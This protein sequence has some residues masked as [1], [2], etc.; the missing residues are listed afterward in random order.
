RLDTDDPDVGQQRLEDDGDAGDEAT[1]ADRHQDD[2]QLG[3]F[4]HQFERQ[5]A[6]AG[7]DVRVVERVDRGQATL[8]P[9]RLVRGEQVA[10]GEDDLG[11]V[12][13]GRL[14]LGWD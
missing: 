7:D 6:V 2:V 12:R 13:A 4:G 8:V 10:V 9:H 1:T 11:A 3:A 5:A 14:D